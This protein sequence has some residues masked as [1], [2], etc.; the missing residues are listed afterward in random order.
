MS[1]RKPFEPLDPREFATARGAEMANAAI[2]QAE[3][4]HL[5]FVRGIQRSHREL[6]DALIKERGA[7]RQECNAARAE[8]ERLQG[9]DE[10]LASALRVGVKRETAFEELRAE[11]SQHKE[12][13]GNYAV[14]ATNQI[15]ELRAQL[16]ASKAQLAE[17]ERV[18]AAQ[19]S[20]EE[21]HPYNCPCTVCLGGN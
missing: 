6:E 7:F 3:E 11:L 16:C 5:K 17:A 10:A 14:L 4:Y 2:A 13:H 9:V 19:G 12:M 20:K 18:I 15:M 8:V 21:E 1:N